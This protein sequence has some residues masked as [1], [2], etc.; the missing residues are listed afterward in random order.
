[1]G[2]FDAKDQADVQQPGVTMATKTLYRVSVCV[3]GA[4]SVTEINICMKGTFDEAHDYCMYK[5][6]NEIEHHFGHA[7]V[8]FWIT[9]ETRT[10][11]GLCKVR[12]WLRPDGSFKVE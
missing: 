9:Q 2:R 5:Y 11:L 8:R 12:F 10:E 4:A 3:Q 6:S 7:E 1:M